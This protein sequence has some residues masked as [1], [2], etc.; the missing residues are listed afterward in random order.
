MCSKHVVPV[1]LQKQGALLC[2]RGEGGLDTCLVTAQPVPCTGSGTRTGTAAGFLIWAASCLA[3]SSQ[4]ALTSAVQIVLGP[5]VYGPSVTGA[6]Y[7]FNGYWLWWRMSR[8]FGRKTT[9]GDTSAQWCT[10][11]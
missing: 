9:T 1:M 5:H 2:Q 3:P 4:T 7:G 11:Q 6:I 8:S 10:G